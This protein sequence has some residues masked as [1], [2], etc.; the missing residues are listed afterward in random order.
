[1]LILG[2]N[3]FHAD[4][5]A[6]LLVDGDLVAA[7]EEERFTREKHASGLPV[8]SMRWV[9]EE[10]EVKPSDVDHI[11]FSRN[12]HVH[13]ARRAAHAAV[14]SVRT[15]D[16][17][18]ERMASR[19]SVLDLGDQVR[20]AFSGALSVDAGMHYVEHHPAHIASAFYPSGLE[21]AAVCSID[22]LGDFVSM[23]WG[24]GR[25][26]EIDLDHRVFFPHSLGYFYT[27]ITQFLGFPHYG[28][29]YKV[30]GLAPYGRPKYVAEMR[31]IL[32]PSADAFTLDMHFFRFMRESV[33][34]HFAGGPPIVGQLWSREMEGLLGP[35]RQPGDSLDQRHR[36][37]AASAQAHLE[38]VLLPILARL[39]KTTGA[40]T[41]TMAGGVAL[42]V[43]ANSKI[44][45]STGFEDIYIQP[46][47]GDS[48]TSVG[49]AL[50]VAH[51]TLR[52][53]RAFHMKHAYYGPSFTSEE[54]EAALEDAGLEFERLDEDTLCKRAAEEIAA[55]KILG[56][57]QGRME[58]GP[59]AL[60]N[61][62]IVCDPRR[63]DMKDILNSRTKRRE[64]FRPFAPSVLAER[65]SDVY[66]HDGASP[67]MLFA[68]PVRSEWRDRIPAVTHVDGTGRIQTVHRETNERYWK[69]IRAF[70][71]LTGVP[72]VLNTSFNENEPIVCTPTEAVNCFLRA[73]MDVLVLTDLIVS[74]N[75]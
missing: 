40:R 12:P 18:R 64:G 65:V 72:V 17:F 21:D 14:H 71:E 58:F 31:K 28:D 2:V 68:P 52:T 4:T 37:I 5:S 74:P 50:Y 61:R 67:F 49:A 75:P 3:A 9:L 22:G 26:T 24:V 23:A 7:V 39:H 44:L 66:D 13:K 34:L 27:A 6:A 32:C 15:R 45:E 59:R 10:A 56:W 36:D 11:A 1:M 42:N 41:L 57:F 53:P 60:G 48:G 70:D 19:K 38:D 51:Q 35:S 16:F 55:G 69:L 43:T 46:A 33:E 62:S 63:P 54:C 20:S 25:G 73:D 47:A 8:E 30:M 29:E